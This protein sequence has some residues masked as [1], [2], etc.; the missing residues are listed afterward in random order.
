MDRIQLIA[1]KLHNLIDEMSI[2]QHE[3]VNAT[4]EVQIQRDWD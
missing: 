3:F 1:N 2:T 4:D